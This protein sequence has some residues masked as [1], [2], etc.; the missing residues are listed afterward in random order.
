[1]WHIFLLSCVLLNH[2]NMNCFIKRIC[3]KFNFTVFAYAL[4]P[5]KTFHK[6]L[7]SLGPSQFCHFFLLFL[8]MNL[9]MGLS[10]LLGFRTT[11]FWLCCSYYILFS[12]HSFLLLFFVLSIHL[13]SLKLLFVILTFKMKDLPPNFLGFLSFS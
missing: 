1:M 5:N 4:V 2:Y 11:K 10:I 12:V 8:L 3:W 7:L 9:I 13:I 6:L